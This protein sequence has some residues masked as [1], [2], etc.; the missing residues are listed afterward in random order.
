MGHEVQKSIP[1][2]AKIQKKPTY[3]WPYLSALRTWGTLTEVLFD[4]S[5]NGYPVELAVEHCHNLFRLANQSINIVSGSLHP[6]FWQ[7][8]RILDALRDRIEQGVS[9]SV[10]C[11]PESN[12]QSFEAL[13]A[14]KP[15]LLRRLP[16]VP[17]IHFMV[18]DNR[19]VRFEL[20]HPPV[21]ERRNAFTKRNIPEEAAQWKKRFQ[22]LL[23]PTAI[24]SVNQT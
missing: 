15:E 4:I 17:K 1:P 8:R 24:S 6:F 20:A 10:L 5:P 22:E 12:D 13:Q 14:L 16:E 9:V 11:G 3:G 21:A 7:D 18:V 2:E 19:H 23:R